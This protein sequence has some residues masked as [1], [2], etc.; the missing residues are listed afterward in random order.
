MIYFLLLSSILMVRS[1]TRGPLSATTIPTATLRA[2]S[3][4]V[5]PRTVSRRAL[6]SGTIQSGAL[7]ARALPTGAL[8]TTRA[9]AALSSTTSTR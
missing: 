8:S 3:R 4:A 6:S 5:P 2:A 7:S 9:P 1:T